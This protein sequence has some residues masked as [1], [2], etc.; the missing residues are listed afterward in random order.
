MN[1][2]QEF[3][4]VISPLV[5]PSDLEILL[6]RMKRLDFSKPVIRRLTPGSNDY[7][8]PDTNPTRPSR[9]VTLT[10]GRSPGESSGGNH[11][12]EFTCFVSHDVL[13][14]SLLRKGVHPPKSMVHIAYYPNF[15]KLYKFPSLS[16]SICVF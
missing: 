15:H 7:T 10:G 12:G 9:H 5:T 11:R 1:S 14:L 13:K 4:K 6:E 3:S 8:N 16:C 2:P